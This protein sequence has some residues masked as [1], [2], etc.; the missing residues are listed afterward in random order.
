MS[1]GN[2]QRTVGESVNDVH[3]IK[4]SNYVQY[5]LSNNDVLFYIHNFGVFHG[6]NAPNCFVHVHIVLNLYLLMIFM[7]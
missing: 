6:L 7:V 5:S 1:I 2:R 4:I 3:N